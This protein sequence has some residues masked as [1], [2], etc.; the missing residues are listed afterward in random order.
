[1]KRKFFK[2]MSGMADKRSKTMISSVIK[3]GKSESELQKMEVGT[4]GHEPGEREKYKQA[5]IE[6]ICNV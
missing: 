2:A 6:F 1:M 3:E 5:M 4:F